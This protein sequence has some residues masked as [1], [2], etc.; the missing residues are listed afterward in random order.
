VCADDGRG[1]YFRWDHDMGRVASSWNIEAGGRT[2][3]GRYADGLV[4]RLDEA[5][6]RQVETYA[7]RPRGSGYPGE[8]AARD[9]LFPL[10]WRSD[11]P[12]KKISRIGRTK[13]ASRSARNSRKPG[14]FADAN[15]FMTGLCAQLGLARQ[16]NPGLRRCCDFMMVSS[17][18]FRST[19]RL[20]KI[21]SGCG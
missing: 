13:R 7:L 21:Q 8:T 19:R 16:A 10:Y 3:A 9:V 17:R 15:R 4:R 2:K 18:S 12:P 14:P 20:P 5:G 11:P 6:L 1:A